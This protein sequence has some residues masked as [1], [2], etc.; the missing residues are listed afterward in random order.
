MFVTWLL[1]RDVLTVR[2]DVLADDEA[3]SISEEYAQGALEFYD[4]TLKRNIALRSLLGEEGPNHFTALGNIRET[5]RT[6]HLP[7]VIRREAA[8]TRCQK[9][10]EA[11]KN[12]A[13]EKQ[14][15][16]SSTGQKA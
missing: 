14:K 15:Q 5:V 12:S 1:V 11:K 6:K 16:A 10:A 3:A 4:K 8:A 13:E 7:F 9:L 2:R